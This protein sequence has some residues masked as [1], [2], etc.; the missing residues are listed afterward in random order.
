MQI[1]AKHFTLSK[2]QIQFYDNNGYLIVPYVYDKEACEAIMAAAQKVAKEDFSVYLNIHRDVPLFLEIAKDP[3]LV[4]AVKAVQRHKITLTNDQFLYKKAGTIY[5]KQAWQPHQ[6]NAYLKAPYGAYMQLHI[7]LEKSEREN[8]GLYCYPE[9]HREDLLPYEYVQS[10][11]E[12]PDVDGVTRPGWKVVPPEK[13]K[14]IDLE[15]PQ[16]AICFQHGHL[17]HG[18]HP[19]LTKNRSRQQFSLAYLNEG[20]PFEKGSTSPKIPVAVE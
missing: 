17:I 8:G 13:Y 7:F 10:W 4:A 2:E 18:S 5:G 6:D 19:N 3:V 15:A 14:C 12:K 9:S 1:K 20:V 11:R 16:G